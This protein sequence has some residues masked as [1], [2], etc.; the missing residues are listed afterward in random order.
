MAV[1]IDWRV[2][3]GKVRTGSDG[4]PKVINGPLKSDQDFGGDIRSQITVFGFLRRRYRDLLFYVFGLWTRM[5]SQ[6]GP[7][8]FSMP[9]LGRDLHCLNCAP[10][11][12][13]WIQE[14]CHHFYSLPNH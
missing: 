4:K 1:S 9:S 3:H 14:P 5:L 11:E 8:P 7:P 6:N 10:G 12:T 13:L 2:G